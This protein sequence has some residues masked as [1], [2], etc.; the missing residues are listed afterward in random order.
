MGEF[1]HFQRTTIYHG[2]PAERVLLDSY[3]SLEA[4]GCLHDLTGTGSL[5]FVGGGDSST[6]HAS[7]WECPPE[8]TQPW[9]RHLICELGA[10]QC[11]DQY[12]GDP[13]NRR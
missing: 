12:V 5:D 6:K 2:I 3:P 11:H 4:G 8:P 10:G 9:T 13:E 7:W 1:P